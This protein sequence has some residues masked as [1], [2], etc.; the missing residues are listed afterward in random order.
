MAPTVRIATYSHAVERRTRGCW[1]HRPRQRRSARQPRRP[2]SEELDRRKRHLG[3]GRT[4]AGVAV[5]ADRAVGVS[6]TASRGGRAH[7]MT[8]RL[9]SGPINRSRRTGKGRQ[10]RV[11]R[12]GQRR[13]E[14]ARVLMIGLANT[15]RRQTD[16]RRRVSPVTP[17]GRTDVRSRTS[18][19][20]LRCEARGSL[21]RIYHQPLNEGRNL[22]G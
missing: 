14:A 3:L 16:V 11:L 17:R 21:D 15:G 9:R 1:T 22:S 13:G 2:N 7:E 19:R 6:G 5:D 10:R 20:G 12:R 4:P 18:T 8:P